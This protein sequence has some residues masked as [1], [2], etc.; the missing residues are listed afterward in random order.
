MPTLPQL[1][2]PF[3]AFRRTAALA[4]LAGTVGVSG[5]QAGTTTFC[6]PANDSIV[7]SPGLFAIVETCPTPAIAPTVQEQ[8]AVP[9]PPAPLGTDGCV[10]RVLT[11]EGPETLPVFAQQLRRADQEPPAVETEALPVDEEAAEAAVLA[12]QRK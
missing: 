10:V 11:S 3:H 7:N 4:L 12:V 5:V 9:A 6:A 8:T 2:S 1:V